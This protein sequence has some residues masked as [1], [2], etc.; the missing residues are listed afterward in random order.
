MKCVWNGCPSHDNNKPNYPLCLQQQ[1][2]TRLLDHALSAL[3]SNR[4]DTKVEWTWVFRSVSAEGWIEYRANSFFQGCAGNAVKIK[5]LRKIKNSFVFLFLFFTQVLEVYSPPPHSSTSIEFHRKVTSSPLVWLP[6][7]AF[8]GARQE[9]F[10]QLKVQELYVPDLRLMFEHWP[11]D[12]SL[13]IEGIRASVPR[14][15]LR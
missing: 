12:I 8:S 7:M 6:P 13:E 5:G 4:H 15:I 9:L 10:A 1:S 2:R 3:P 14:R 11:T